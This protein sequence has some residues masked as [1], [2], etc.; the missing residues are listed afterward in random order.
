MPLATNAPKVLKRYA[1]RKL[2]DP[3]TSKYVTLS[4]ITEFLK[5][6]ITVTI[7]ENDTKED[8]TKK[9]LAQILYK[10]SEKLSN[11]LL[12]NLVKTF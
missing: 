4:D 11:D 10:N 8:A 5:D 1:N 3:Q 9:V 6:G 2:Y 12:I 7:F